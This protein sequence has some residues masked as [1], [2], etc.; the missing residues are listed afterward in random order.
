MPTSPVTGHPLALS[1][2]TVTAD[3][4]SSPDLLDLSISVRI[5][6]DFEIELATIEEMPTAERRELRIIPLLLSMLPDVMHLAGRNRGPRQ[7]D[8]APRSYTLTLTFSDGSAATQSW[9]TT[10]E[11]PRSPVADSIWHLTVP[12]GHSVA[13]AVLPHLLEGIPGETK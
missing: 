1:S 6:G 5:L 7:D 10:F 3:G 4:T 2:A 11:V 13:P 12:F 9:S 8:A